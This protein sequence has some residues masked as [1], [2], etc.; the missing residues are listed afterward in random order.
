MPRIVRDANIDWE[1]N[2][3]RGSGRRQ[4]SHSARSSS[5]SPIAVARRGPRG[6]D[7]PGGAAR[8]RARDVLR[9]LARQRAR[10]RGNAAGAHRRA[11]HDHDGR[12]RGQGAPH[13]RVARS[14]RARTCREPT[15]DAFAAASRRADA[16][17]PFSALIKASATVTVD[18]TLG[19]SADGTERTAHVTWSGSLIEGGGTID[20][21]RQRR[22]RP[23]RR[24]AGRRGRRTRNGTDEP[25]GAHRRRAC[26]VLLDGALARARAG[27][28]AGRSARDVRDG[29]V[30]PGDGNHEDR[31]HGRGSVPGIDEAAFRAAQRAQRRAAPSRGRSPAARDH[32]RRALCEFGAWPPATAIERLVDELE[33]SYARG[34]GAAVRPCRLQRPPPGGGRGPPAEG[35]RDAEASSPTRGAQARA[36]LEAARDDPELAGMAAEL[37]AEVERARG[38]AEARARRAR[39]GGREGRDRRGPPG[40]R[41]RRGGA[42]GRTTS[43]GCCTRYAE[44][45]RLQDG[46]ALDERE[47]G[48]RDQGGRVRGEGAGRVLGLQ[49]RGRH[50]S[51]AARARDRVAGPDP[52]VDRDGRRDARGRGGRGR[53]RGE[54]PEGRRHA[55]DRAGRA[56]REHDRL[57]RADH[58]SSDRDRRGDAGREVAAPE[59]GRRRC[60]CCAR[61]CT[62]SSARS[63]RPS[64]RRTRRSQIGSGERAEKI[65]TYNFP[66]NRVTD[67]RIKLTMHRLDQVAR[68][69]PRASFTEAL[70]GRGAAAGARRRVA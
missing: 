45:L 47:R 49:V 37:E 35:A 32:A 33:R 12:G 61:V 18:A 15:T 66:E 53:D 28:H 59:P 41:R 70:R 22:V 64:S 13:R 44:R 4:R 57:R 62:R 8:G 65:R 27:G 36:D 67:H 43:R 16:G 56:E 1:G 51:R 29:D 26:G 48:R 38:G 42:L 60:A 5:P 10:A 17:C 3:A 24:D 25:G 7:E 40:R 52:H 31:A 50:A 14:R 55:L 54:R 20:E 19:G 2:V 34:A 9:D 23:A 69:R 30:R 11:L 6:E 46:D 63:S 39:S 21:R 58:P 68:R